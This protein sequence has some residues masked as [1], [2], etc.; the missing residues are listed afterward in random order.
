MPEGDERVEMEMFAECL[1][2]PACLGANNPVLEGTYFDAQG[3]DLAATSSVDQITTRNNSRNTSSSNG[4]C[5][6]KQGYRS[7]ST[8]CQACIDGFARSATSR[9]TSCTEGK[10]FLYVF[11]TGVFFLI[12]GFITLIVLKLK[13][14]SSQQGFDAERRRK[15]THSTLKRI[16]LTHMQTITLV[17]GLTIPWPRLMLDALSV[18][19]SVSSFAESANSLECLY[20]GVRDS[21]WHATFYYSLL[22]VVAFLPMGILSVL[23]LF[24]FGFLP[25]YCKSRGNESGGGRGIGHNEKSNVRCCG[26]D[27]AHNLTASLNPND[28]WAFVYDRYVPSTTDMFVGSSVL[29][30]FLLL[31]S[32][33]QLAFAVFECRYIG[34]ATV[35]KPMYLLVSM[36]EQCW[37][38]RHVWFAF[39]VGLPMLTLYAVVAPFVIVLR[40]RRARAEGDRKLENPSLMLR[41]GLFY[42]GYRS[43]RYWW[44]LV[45]LSR[46]IAVIIVSTFIAQDRNQLQLVLATLI[47]SLHLHHSQTPFGRGT[48]K[49]DLLHYFE[50]SSVSVLIFLAWSGVYFSVSSDLCAANGALW[51]TILAVLLILLN[52]LYVLVLVGKCFAS[53]SKRAKVHEVITHHMSKMGRSSRILTGLRSFSI[54]RR[55]SQSAG[56]EKVFDTKMSLER[57][58]STCNMDLDLRGLNVELMENPFAL[59]KASGNGNND[60]GGGQAKK[61]DANGIDMPEKTVCI[62][63]VRTFKPRGSGRRADVLQVHEFLDIT[64]EDLAEAKTSKFS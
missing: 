64:P 13:S 27:L 5:N 41:F 50:V 11:Y 1:Y 54:T 9:C 33:V 48:P 47:I 31:P 12:A 25:R 38:G 7:G 43:D 2:P 15:A 62:E 24:W 4:P 16:M 57:T 30:W 63:M 42:S 60:G 32:L 58:R 34:K 61:S 46:K 26:M 53:W 3:N 45:V 59:E 6:E 36:E 37:V 35:R 20:P 8:L 51:C 28:E 19:S 22:T 40:L 29:L 17:L 44:E 10:S 18:L 23:A 21:G 39:G 56:E 55:S 52:A 49:S 14:F